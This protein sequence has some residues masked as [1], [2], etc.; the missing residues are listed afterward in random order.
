M[1]IYPIDLHP[2]F[3]DSLAA[4]QSQRSEPTSTRSRFSFRKAKDAVPNVPDGFLDAHGG[5][6]RDLLP[7]ELSRIAKIER[8]DPIVRLYFATIA[9]LADR[10]ITTEAADRLY[11]RGLNDALDAYLRFD[12][13]EARIGK[14]INKI[15]APT[16]YSH[17]RRRLEAQIS[18]TQDGIAQ[19]VLQ[20][21]LGQLD[22]RAIAFEALQ[23]DLER[24]AARKTAI[25][26]RLSAV[27]ELLILDSLNT[28][29]GTS[30]GGGL[31]LLRALNDELSKDALFAQKAEAELILNSIAS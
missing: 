17:E 20:D 26:Q 27:R 8:N 30:D 16:M 5:T 11:L 7:S 13:R 31:T 19:R 10:T 14:A 4:L 18:S 24:I 15:G 9:E 3:A 21:A 28:G 6:R 25:A 12:T 29:E 2:S 23:I 1:E 22:A